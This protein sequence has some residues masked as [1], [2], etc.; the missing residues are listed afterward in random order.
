[1]QGY[2]DAISMGPKSCARASQRVLVVVRLDGMG[3]SF[4]PTSFPRQR[5]RLEPPRHGDTEDGTRHFRFRLHDRAR[6]LPSHACGSR[7]CRD[8]RTGAGGD[9]TGVELA[10]HALL[11]A[12]IGARKHAAGM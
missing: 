5:R 2:V 8:S 1:M 9:G 4:G 6:V 12:T 11:Q 3:G 7:T 10:D